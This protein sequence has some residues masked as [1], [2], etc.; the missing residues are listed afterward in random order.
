MRKEAGF[1][2]SD[3]IVVYV[4]GDAET[5][6]TVDAFREYISGEVLARELIVGPTLPTNANVT[7]S[8]ELDGLH[9]RVA[10]TRV[11]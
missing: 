1:A 8:L 2:V 5:E 9:A 4:A 10:L 7:Q 3:R 11:S 6:N